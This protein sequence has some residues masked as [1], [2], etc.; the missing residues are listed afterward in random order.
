MKKLLSSLVACLATCLALQAEP[1]VKYYNDSTETQHAD[2]EEITITSTRINNSGTLAKQEIK[3]EDLQLTNTGVNL[4]FLLQ[5]TPSLVATSDDGLGIGY[6][7]FRIRGTDHTRINTTVNGVPLNDSESQTVF[8]VNMTDI[9]SSTNS[10]EVQ[11]G[12]GTSTNGAAAFGASVNMQTSKASPEPY[13]QLSFNG[14]MYNTFRE[15]AKIGTG[16]MP[17]GFAFDARVS[18]VN[19]DGYLER[20]YSDL[21]SYYASGA[22]YGDQT[23]VKLLFFGGNETTYMAW[24]GVSADDLKT[25]RRYNPAGQYIDDDGNIAYYNNQTDNYAQQHV[26]LHATHSFNSHWDLNAALHYTHGAGYY[27]QYKCDA[28]LAD[29]GITPN[30]F[31]NILS[32]YLSSTNNTNNSCNLWGDI[33][34][35]DLVR[36]KHLGNHFYGAVAAVNYHSTNLQA[37]IGGGA[38]NYNGNHWGNVIW[39]RTPPQI[40]QLLTLNSQ[41]SEY[42]RSRGDKFDANIYAKANWQITKE[43]NLYGDLQYRHI[44]YKIKGIN[45]EDLSELDVHKTYN[46]FNPKAGISYVHQG[47]TGYFNFAVAN[48]EPSRANFTEAGI[49]DI[50]LPERLYDYEFGYQ[51]L[52]R[53]FGVGANFYFMDYY[54]QLVLTGQYSDVGAYLTKN[55]DRS[56][57]MGVELTAG[58]E[59]TKWLRWDVNATLS[60]N[61]IINFSD[62]A[63]DW[64]ADW[65]DPVVAEHGG[66]VLVNYG[67]TNISFS[68]NIIAGSNIQF[69]HKGFQANLLTNYVGKQYLDNTN[70]RN[71]MLDDYCV[72]NLRL[73]YTLDFNKEN[74]TKTIKN[75]SFH[76]LL[77]NLFNTRYESNGGVYG[78]F[79]GADAN[80]NYLPEN[81]LHTPWY[82]A[83]AGINVHGGFTINF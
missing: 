17:S 78:Y 46:F 69:D 44:D 74:Q 15:E 82:Y 53:R 8:W 6:T 5:M 38:N 51:Y 80:G 72:S 33:K 45:D 47:H 30:S 10:V 70:N 71:A 56:Y 39:L 65:D 19:S 76:I 27:E 57:R 11:R 40:S 60:M 29:Y 48:R 54:N 66:Q 64:Y 77:N 1:V 43:L 18:K 12:V 61:K 83:Q 59:I 34:S 25:N 22:W 28:K 41:L 37:T 67:T 36:Q 20:A 23:M 75:I 21:L 55:V 35:S 13:T 14:G 50:P 73:A 81:Q 52:H 68:P 24:D 4:P 79:E 31:Q 26:Q 42:Y 62:W 32:Q 58:V 63:D 49:N 16:I 7:Y 3:S 9:A 2:L